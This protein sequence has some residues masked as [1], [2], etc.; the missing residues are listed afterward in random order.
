MSPPGLAL[1]EEAGDDGAKGGVGDDKGSLMH[2]L[3]EEMV[4]ACARWELANPGTL[5]GVVACV[6]ETRHVV[7]KGMDSGT[8]DDDVTLEVETTGAVIRDW[9]IQATRQG[10][11]PWIE[12]A[13][14]VA[15][16]EGAEVSLLLQ[17]ASSAGRNPRRVG[18]DG[19]L[20]PGEG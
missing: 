13:L 2:G 12:L 16:A 5:V 14:E 4:D 11:D 18:R 20:V 7:I 10:S 15:E 9:D 1:E 3:R 19:F 6:T 17:P 8:V